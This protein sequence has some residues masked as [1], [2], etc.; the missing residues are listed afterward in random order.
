M[1]RK[2]KIH[3]IKDYENYGISYSGRVYSTF[4]K[5]Y[6][7]PRI[8]KEGYKYVN[9]YNEEGKKTFKIHRLV[10]EYFLDKPNVDEK[11]CVNHKDG[12][13]LNNH[14]SN[15]EWCTY[16][17]N[18]RH[19]WAMGMQISTEKMKDTS[20]KNGKKRQLKIMV[21]N[22]KTGERSIY[23]CLNDFLREKNLGKRSTVYSALRRNNLLYG[24]Y[25]ICYI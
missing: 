9:L 22:I 11:L 1:K 13:K 7:K 6:L 19:S 21:Y 15:L 14:F 16:S 12:D 4:T 24:M 5:K 20:R 23:D 17:E 2:D 3:I 18:S 8:G 10:A 25:K